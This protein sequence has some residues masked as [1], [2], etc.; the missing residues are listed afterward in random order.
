M[1]EIKSGKTI[2]IQELTR[3]TSEKRKCAN[4]LDSKKRDIIKI[5]E[6]II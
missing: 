2:N 6:R 4:N 1:I 3:M 5:K